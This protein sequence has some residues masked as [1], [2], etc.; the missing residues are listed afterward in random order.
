MNQKS[1]AVCQDCGTT[2]NLL[3]HHI[4]YSP[5]ITKTLCKSCHL[6]ERKQKLPSR[7]FVISKIYPS[8]NMA[9]IP[10]PVREEIGNLVEIATGPNSAFFF[11][12]NTPLEDV[13]RS[14]EIVLQDIKL[15]RKLEE[16]NKKQ[17]KKKKPRA[18]G[19]LLKKEVSM[20]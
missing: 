20:E 4:S 9:Y 17:S 1:N 12:Y 19:L 18:K 16:Q 13:K 15:R 7:G 5:E 2:E 6:K 10:E 14:L 8:A 11:P 3:E